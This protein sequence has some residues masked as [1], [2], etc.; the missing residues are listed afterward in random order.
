MRKCIL[1]ADDTE[2]MRLLLRTV[3]LGSDF[4]VFGEAEDGDAALRLWRTA[5]P[6]CALVLDQ[7]MPGRTG[8]EV[9]REVLQ[10]APDTTIILFSA[11]MDDDLRREAKAIG[12]RACVSKDEILSL[13]AH[14]VLQA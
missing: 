6:T 12:I 3:F 14:P 7:R 4:N 11:H 5:P 8:L 9:A 13:P 1:F 2:D 10:H